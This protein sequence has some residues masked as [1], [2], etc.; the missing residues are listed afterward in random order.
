MVIVE[1]PGEAVGQQAQP[2]PHQAPPILPV[3]AARIPSLLH[4]HQPYVRAASVIFIDIQWAYD[5]IGRF[6]SLSL[7]LCAPPLGAGGGGV[8]KKL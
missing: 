4:H 8:V 3:Q 2:H 1:T 5:N 7:S 6:I